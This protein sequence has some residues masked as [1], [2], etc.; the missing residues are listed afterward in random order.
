MKFTD[1]SIG[2]IVYYEEFWPKSNKT[3]SLNFG[4][5]STFDHANYLCLSS[6][7]AQ[8]FL[9]KLSTQCKRCLWIRTT[10]KFVALKILFGIQISIFISPWFEI[11]NFLFRI[12]F[13]KP[14]LHFNGYF[15][16]YA[17]LNSYFNSKISH[18]LS[19]FVIECWE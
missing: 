1:A 2:R 3:T 5:F 17:K 6:N 9:S 16:N 10:Y 18:F 13:D 8:W 19:I 4:N 7:F 15:V 11:N 14:F 12:N